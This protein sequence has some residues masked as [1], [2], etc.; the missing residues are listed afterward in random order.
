MPRTNVF[1]SYS[2]EDDAWRRR[3]S[4]HVAILFREGLIDLWS[5]RQ[6][7]VGNDWE[8]EIEAA[9]TT[10]RVALLLISPAYLASEYIWKNEIPRIIAHSKDGMRIVPL[11]VRPCAWRLAK[12]LSRLQARPEDERALSAG[13]EAQI[14]ADLSALVYELANLIADSATNDRSTGAIAFVGKGSQVVGKWTGTYNQTRQIK[15]LISKGNHNEF[16]G[17]MEYPQ[18]GTLTEIKGFIHPQ[19]SPSDPNWIQLG[20]D[21]NGPYSFAITFRETGYN[22][23]GRNSINFDGEYRAVLKGDEMIGAWFSGARLVGRFS[24]QRSARNRKSNRV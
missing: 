4:Q 11:I 22:K 24:L 21:G 8:K 2:H 19:W 10:A 5:D 16:Y 20:G 9:L 3:L 7:G 14:D 13:S 12:E 18:E 17:V 23:Q 6:I 15:L 1:I